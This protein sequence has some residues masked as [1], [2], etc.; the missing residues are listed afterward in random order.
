MSDDRSSPQ[1]A[2]LTHL[3]SLES[4]TVDW[5][6]EGYTVSRS[7]RLAAAGGVGVG[8]D[9]LHASAGGVERSS[10]EL[11][12]DSMQAGDPACG[13]DSTAEEPRTDLRRI[14][15]KIESWMD[16]EPGTGLP[17]RVVFL[18]GSFRFRGIVEKLDQVWVR[19]DPDGIPRRGHLRLTMRG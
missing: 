9:R 18:W 6:P 5:N 4:V 17:P 2:S 19:F 7:S 8:R 12:L 16:P 11:F 15:E 3:G 13:G 1:R 14:V 10:T